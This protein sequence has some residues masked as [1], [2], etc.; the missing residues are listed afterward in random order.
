MAEEMNNEREFFTLTD[1]D[2]NEIEFE[3]ID[4]AEYK[5]ATYYAVSISVCK[6]VKALLSGTDCTLTVS[7]MCNGEYG[8]NDVCLSLLSIVGNKCANGKILLPL[9]DKEIEA[10]HNSANALK[11]VIKA[12]EI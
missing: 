12:I 6:V 5:G 4:I 8:L 7:T 10:L 11:N 3:L 1:E 2:G 9:N